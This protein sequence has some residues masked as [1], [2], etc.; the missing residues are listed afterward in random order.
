[1]FDHVVL[2]LQVVQLLMFIKHVQ[3]D[4]ILQPFQVLLL[5]ALHVMQPLQ[6]LVQV[7]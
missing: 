2:V 3:L 7:E 6:Q 1:V 5:D 4:F